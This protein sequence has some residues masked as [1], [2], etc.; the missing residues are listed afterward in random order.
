MSSVNNH[1]FGMRNRTS[2][3]SLGREGERA[4]KSP[5]THTHTPD[6]GFRLQGHW[7]VNLW[8]PLDRCQSDFAVRY[9]IELV[10]YVRLDDSKHSFSVDENSVFYG[11]TCD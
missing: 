7:S 4:I 3:L 1:N 10:F 9:K 2:P 8:K 5:D 6:L 11:G